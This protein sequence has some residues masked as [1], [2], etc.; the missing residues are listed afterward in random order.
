MKS[1]DALFT[2]QYDAAAIFFAELAQRPDADELMAPWTPE[3]EK[4]VKRKV[5][6]LLRRQDLKLI[7]YHSLT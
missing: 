4:A 1:A 6:V 2:F 5:C 3:E 7:W